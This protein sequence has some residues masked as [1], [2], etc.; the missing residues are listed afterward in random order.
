MAVVFGD[1]GSEFGDQYVFD[2]LKQLP[3]RFVIYAQPEIHTPSGSMY[4]DYVIL[5]K[6][7]GVLVVEVKDW[8]YI[9]A[10]TH[11]NAKVLKSS[12]WDYLTLTSPVKQARQTSYLLREAFEMNQRLINQYGPH[13]G[14]T[15]VPVGYVGVL[16]HQDRC[17][18]GKLQRCWGYGSVLGRDDLNSTST[19]I[20]ILS[21]YRYAFMFRPDNPEKVYS[22]IHQTLFPQ[23]HINM[24]ERENANVEIAYA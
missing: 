7:C 17:S 10:A 8:K 1:S 24:L 21:N 22:E 12:G 15:L 19:T 6:Q 14:K 11:E 4:P 16:P 2:R 20:D 18:I 23:I 3:D 5:D 13:K 9:L